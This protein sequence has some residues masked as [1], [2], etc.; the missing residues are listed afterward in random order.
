MKKLWNMKH[1][2]NRNYISH[3]LNGLQSVRKKSRVIR[4]D[5]NN[6]DVT[7]HSLVKLG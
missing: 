2:C 6:L 7:D 1:D 4:N 3:A 5:K